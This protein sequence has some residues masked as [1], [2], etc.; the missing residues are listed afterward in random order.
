[1][2]AVKVVPEDSFFQTEL[3][4]AGAK[5]VV[6]DF[7]ATWCGPCKRIAPF[8]DELSS[9]YDRAVFLKVNLVLLIIA[10]VK[11]FGFFR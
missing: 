10:I 9:K 3:A 1:M 11:I 5:L 2:S 4:S 8:F 6:V 7:T